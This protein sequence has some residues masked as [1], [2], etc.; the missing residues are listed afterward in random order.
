MKRF[1]ILA[2]FL[3][4][5]AFSQF[6]PSDTVDH[7]IMP[8]D[9]KMMLEAEYKRLWEQSEG[10][11]LRLKEEMDQLKALQQSAAI[12]DAAS[13]GIRSPAEVTPSSLGNSLGNVPGNN[14]EKSKGS[15]KTRSAPTTRL[16]SGVQIFAVSEEASLELTVLPA[17]SWVRAKL[18]TGV[19]ANAKYPYNVLL[20]LDYAYT[21]PNG[22]KIPL[23]GC[24]VLGGA[25][26]DLSIERV[27]I[28]PHTLSCVR[29]N[30]EYLQRK[31]TGFVAGR[32]S[33]NG[34]MGVYDS[35]QSQVFLQA[36]LA[37][38]V[39]G[40]S[41][42]YQIANTTVALANGTNGAQTPVQNFNGR[43]EELAVAE[44]VGESAEM[45]T[46]WYLEQAKALLPTIHVGSGQDVWIVMTDKVDVPDL[47]SF[48]D[49]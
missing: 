33:S 3:S 20:Q 41:K 39:K 7:R 26:A 24:L 11:N 6:E 35:K 38:V 23:N 49:Y 48:D 43:F 8:H 2:L 32:D 21:G 10:E 30:G 15:S 25:T 18:L 40:A 5:A 34:M 19:Q 12:K 9:P 16:A 45:V 14:S 27:I 17:G 1:S 42:A 29:D 28:S 31:V 46:Q 36:V 13:S 37:G 44:G 22:V 4:S 47:R